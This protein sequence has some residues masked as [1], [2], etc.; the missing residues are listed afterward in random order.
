MP[1]PDPL[2]FAPDLLAPHRRATPTRLPR[3]DRTTSR[4]ASSSRRFASYEAAYA[5]RPEA[6]WNQKAFVAACNLGDVAK[7][8]LHWARLSPLLQKRTLGICERNQITEEMLS[9]P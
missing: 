9:A 8:R 4:G 7:A 2:S 1:P 6:Q 3:P 5:C